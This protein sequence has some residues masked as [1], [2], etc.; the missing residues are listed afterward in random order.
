MRLAVR[1]MRL[2]VAP[3]TIAWSVVFRG[4]KVRWKVIAVPAAAAK[5]PA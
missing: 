1:Y 5:T 2:I 4:I 3:V